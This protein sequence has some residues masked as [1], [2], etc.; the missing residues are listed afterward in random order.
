MSAA[1]WGLKATK[2]EDQL[3]RQWG[4]DDWQF[5]LSI[6]SPANV[7]LCRRDPKPTLFI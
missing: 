6:S 7:L 2:D 1:I 5:L 3:R 4:L